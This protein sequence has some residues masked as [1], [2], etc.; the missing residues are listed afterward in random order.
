MTLIIMKN[1]NE[2]KLKS[3]K[4]EIGT[5]EDKANLDHATEL[6]NLQYDL[7]QVSAE[8]DDLLKNMTDLEIEKTNEND[9][10]GDEVVSF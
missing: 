2:R 3:L 8:R 6:C 9:H 7:D 1:E 4:N 5:I 10:L